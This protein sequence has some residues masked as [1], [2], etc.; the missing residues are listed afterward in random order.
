M[1]LGRWDQR[2]PLAMARYV[3]QPTLGTFYGIHSTAVH[4]CP[5]EVDVAFHDTTSLSFRPIPTFS[6]LFPP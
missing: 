4:I 3:G 2:T 6:I 1:A 5:P